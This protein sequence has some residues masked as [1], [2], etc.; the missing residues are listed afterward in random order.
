MTTF[1]AKFGEKFI[2]AIKESLEKDEK[3]PWVKNWKLSG[4]QYQNAVTK[5]VY[6]GAFNRFSCSISNHS[7]P[8]YISFNQVKKLNGKVKAGARGVLLSVYCT[9]KSDE[10]PVDTNESDV[11][12]SKNIKPKKGKAM[13]LSH[14][15]F[16]IEDVEGIDFPKIEIEESNIEL[17]IS[18][19]SKFNVKES[20]SCDIPHYNDMCDVIIIPNKERYKTLEG[21]YNTLFHEIIHWTGRSNRLNRHSMIYYNEE[22]PEEELVAEIGSMFLLQHFKIEQKMNKNN[23]AY[24]QSWFESMKKDKS[25]LSRIFSEAEKAS[26]YVIN[27]IEGNTCKEGIDE[28]EEKDYCGVI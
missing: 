20:I 26:N 2:N 25:Y 3:F 6:Q 4:I 28:R 5:Y 7:D 14:Y 24:C 8:R 19:F 15:V 11:D 22:R 21:I 18:K 1:I 27:L 10:E 9:A 23:I 17:D 12:M 16:N 13:L